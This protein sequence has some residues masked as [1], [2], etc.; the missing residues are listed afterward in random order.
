M[1]QLTVAERTV[2]IL[3]LR[4]KGRTIRRIAQRVGVSHARVGQIVKREMLKLDKEISTEA[5]ICRQMDL[6]RLD[7]ALRSI[8]DDVLK[9]DHGAI[10]RLHRNIERR[11]RIMGYEYLAPENMSEDAEHKPFIVVAGEPPKEWKFAKLPEPNVIEGEV[12][13]E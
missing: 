11:A 8:Y 9:G 10:D 5:K 3:R 12:V 13:N 2:E 7:E 1:P 4:R 6:A